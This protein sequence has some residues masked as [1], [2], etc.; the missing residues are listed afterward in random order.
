LNNLTDQRAKVSAY[1]V[2][3]LL[4][5]SLFTPGLIKFELLALNGTSWDVAIL[6]ALPPGFLVWRSVNYRSDFFPKSFVIVVTVLFVWYL[7]AGSRQPSDHH[8]WTVVAMYLRGLSMVALIV[9]A[10]NTIGVRGVV[11]AVFWAGVILSSLAL[12]LYMLNAGDYPWGERR[13]YGDLILMNDEFQ[14]TRIIGFAQDPNFLTIP[15]LFAIGA[16][17]VFPIGW[18]R[19]AGHGFVLGIMSLVVLLTV[20]RSGITGSVIGITLATI[21]VYL[22]SSVRIRKSTLLSAGILLLILVI[23]VITGIKM[24]TSFSGQSVV[25]QLSNRFEQ[26]SESPRFTIWKNILS[27][28]FSDEETT[29]SVEPTAK[30]DAT[31]LVEPTAKADATVPVEPTAKAD[32]TVIVEP[33]AEA[34]ATVIVE[35]TAEPRSGKLLQTIIG[36]GNASNVRNQKVHSHNSYLDIWIE[37]G[38]IGILLWLTIAAIVVNQ[39][40]KAIPLKSDDQT[41]LFAVVVAG[42]SMIGVMMFSSTLMSLP[43]LF[44]VLGL[45]M[46]ISP[47]SHNQ[48]IE[49]D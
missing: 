6:L 39:L 45:A 22:G 32:A 2:F 25:M 16:G 44:V 18:Q 24:T 13:P 43:Y 29:V 9:L 20:S 38:L 48:A 4:F 10:G 35:P 28:R 47:Q 41:R 14:I 33:T 1:L 26:T 46:L 11:R 30:A 37:L 49:A 21:V 36:D 40:R 19:R 12:V 23:V 3:L 7:I 15:T 31:V 34:D 5:L 27:L 17:I 8:S 42:S